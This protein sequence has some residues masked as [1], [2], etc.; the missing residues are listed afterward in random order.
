MAARTQGRVKSFNAGKGFGFI[1]AWSWHVTVVGHLQ[2][3]ATSF[4]SM[5]DSMCLNLIVGKKSKFVEGKVF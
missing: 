3:K 4:L 1:E 5:L 2:E